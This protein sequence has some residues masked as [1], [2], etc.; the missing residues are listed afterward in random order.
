MCGEPEA[1]ELIGDTGSSS[2]RWPNLHGCTN[3]SQR[4]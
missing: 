3:R 1:N 4:V 2:G